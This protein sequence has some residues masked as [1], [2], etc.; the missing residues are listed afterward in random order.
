MP[1]GD[2]YTLDSATLRFQ[3]FGG[4]VNNPQ[5]VKPIV[6]IFSNSNVNLPGT[7]L[8]TL[9]NPQFNFNATANY[10]FTPITPLLLAAN[11]PYWLVVNGRGTSLYNWKANDPPIVPTGLATHFGR[12]TTVNGGPETP[13]DTICSYAIEGTIVPEPDSCVMLLLASGIIIGRWKRR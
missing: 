9:N 6:Q 5:A 3:I 12:L 1:A 7:A 13:N 10:T 8:T 4:S 11:T 2:N